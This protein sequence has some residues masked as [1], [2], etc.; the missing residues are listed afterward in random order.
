[1]SEIQFQLRQA[2]NGEFFFR[3]RSEGNYKI[4][5]HS[6]LYKT[7]ES[8]RHAIDLIKNGAGS[9]AVVEP[10]DAS[11]PEE[12]QGAQDMLTQLFDSIFKTGS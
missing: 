11:S 4:L 3:I 8:A 6:Q 7:E 2:A 5:C 1:M 9:A 12:E 10:G